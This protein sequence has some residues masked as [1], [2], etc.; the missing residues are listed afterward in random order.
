MNHFVVSKNQPDDQ[1]ENICAWE[2]PLITADL[3]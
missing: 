1:K 2:L 3:V